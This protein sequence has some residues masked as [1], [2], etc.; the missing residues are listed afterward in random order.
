ML[1]APNSLVYGITP[2]ILI[3]LKLTLMLIRLTVLMI[4]KAPSAMLSYFLDLLSH[5]EARNNKLLLFPLLKQNTWLPP[6]L[7]LKPF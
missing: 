7:A 4:R 1:V 2:L 5:E 6:M 3:S